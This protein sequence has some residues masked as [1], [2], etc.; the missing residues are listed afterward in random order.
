MEIEIR[1]LRE[2]YI[3]FVNGRFHCS[4]DNMR[5]VDEEIADMKG[6]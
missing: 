1:K 5:E 2:Y 6:E 4:C 3:I